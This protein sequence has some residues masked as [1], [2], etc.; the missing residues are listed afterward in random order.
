[1]SFNLGVNLMIKKIGKISPDTLEDL[2]ELATSIMPLME[3][4]HSNYARGRK[5]IWLFH[6]VNL[7]TSE[8]TAGYFNE[9]L[10]NLAQRFGC[11]IGLM[12]YG[13]KS[14]D[15]TGLISYHRDH[16]YA[17][18][19]AF[20]INL[21]QAIFGYDLNRQ[22][23]D[24]RDFQLNDGDIIQFDCKHPHSL[25]EIQSEIRFG[26]NFWKLNEAKGLKPLI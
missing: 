8:V 15:S 16:S 11:D 6:E 23:G 19:P 2:R 9:R 5:R 4:D 20:T 3:H 14:L 12:S 25:V 18:S 10:W 22:G 13:G 21:G 17:M 1:M 26:I 24:K 7:K